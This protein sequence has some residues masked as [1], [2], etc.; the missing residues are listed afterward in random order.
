M[1]LDDL[2]SACE[3]DPRAA[4]PTFDVPSPLEALEDTG[5][6]SS[7]N[8]QPLISDR[9]DSPWASDLLFRDGHGDGAAL[10]A[11]LDGVGEQILEDALQTHSIPGADQLVMRTLDEDGVMVGE[12]LLVGCGPA[13]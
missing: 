1:L 10:G 3:P 5:Q 7:R 12:L 8:T 13:R 4:D 11:V 9:Q 2:P 6:I